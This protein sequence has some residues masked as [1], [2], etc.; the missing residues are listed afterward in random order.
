MKCIPYGQ[1]FSVITV[2]LQGTGSFQSRLEKGWQRQMRF[3]A[4]HPPF[5]APYFW[6]ACRAYS[7]QVGR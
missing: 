5:H 3:N 6:I 2:V 1:A 7:E 4:I